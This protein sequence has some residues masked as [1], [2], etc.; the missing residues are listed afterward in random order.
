M[1]INVLYR[2]NNG[3]LVPHI[4]YERLFGKRL[5]PKKFLVRNAFYLH[6]SQVFFWSSNPNNSWKKMAQIPY[7]RNVFK[8]V[9]LFARSANKI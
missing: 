1:A 2:Q 9:K 6:F 8:I 7:I 3:G 5:F 4:M